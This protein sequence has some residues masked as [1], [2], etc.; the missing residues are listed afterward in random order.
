MIKSC[1]IRIYPN[2]YQRNKINNIL[3]VCRFL[4]NKYIEVNISAKKSGF[5][6]I[7][8]Y[9]FD[10]Y[11][12]NHLSNEYPWI[13]MV[14]SKARK[15]TIIREEKAFKRLFK[16]C[17]GFPHFKSRKRL[18]KESYFFIKDNIKYT[19]NKY[20]IKIP[21]LGK[22]RITE[23]DYLPELKTITSG[24]VIR[25]YDRYYLM[26]L[27]RTDKYNIKTYRKNNIGIDLGI[28][29]YATCSTKT[30]TFTIS[31]FKNIRKYKEADKRI[32]RLQQ[33]IS[34][35]VEINYAKLYH[36]YLD[37]HQ[38]QEPNK[39]TK[40]I[41]KGESYK[42]SQIRKLMRK[43]RRVKSIQN[44]I[45]RDFINKLLYTL[46]AII[47]PSVITIENLDISEM[48]KHNGTKDTTLHKHIVESA[49]YMFKL[50]LINKCDYYGITIRCADKY[51][52]SS[53]IC[54]HCGHKKKNLTLQDRVYKCNKCGLEINRDE[55][56]S[57]NLLN[58]KD[59]DCLILNNA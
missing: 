11:I 18:N 24:R 20:I 19:N 33:I 26:L 7:T 13:K 43:I 45:R 31:H 16:K 4:Q 22:I 35:K 55:N 9:T 29:E 48:T 1:K 12:N 47:K 56:A 38:C 37:T 2:S 41:M 27:Y 8:G 32:K 15:D 25:E 36:K 51:F 17:G 30:Q 46:T 10:K 52:A 58:L 42:T 23:Y 34:N 50:A 49:F 14:S 44:N 21:I 40:N 6:F 53:K 54:S 5:P 39:I 28:K 59:K 3:G 57:I